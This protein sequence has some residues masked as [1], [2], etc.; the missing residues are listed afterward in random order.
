MEEVGLYFP[1]LGPTKGNTS[2]TIVA[3]EPVPHIYS[4]DTVRILI[5]WCQAFPKNVCVFW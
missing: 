3:I 5:K 4:P 1:S 2:A